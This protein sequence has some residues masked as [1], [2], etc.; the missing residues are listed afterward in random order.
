M[1]MPVMVTVC[2]FCQPPV[3]GAVMEPVTFWPSTLRWKVPP[4][5]WA[6]EMRKAML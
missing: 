5:V 3:A 1:L 4:V 6:S 2:Q